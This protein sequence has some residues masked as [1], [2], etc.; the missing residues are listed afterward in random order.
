MI[1]DSKQSL[2]A[3]LLHN[4]KIFPS[5]SVAH[6][7]HLKESY[8]KIILPP[9]HI[10]LAEAK[11]KE[12]IFVGHDIKSSPPPPS[13]NAWLVFL[14]NHKSLYFHKKTQSRLADYHKVLKSFR[15][16]W[17]FLFKLIC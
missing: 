7:F 16:K 3:V 13:K 1:D 9:S 12:G 8:E 17:I 5:L 2:R 10:K 14:G 4:C 15:L 11:I 6:G